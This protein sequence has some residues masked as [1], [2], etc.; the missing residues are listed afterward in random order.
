MRFKWLLPFS[1]PIVHDFQ[2]KAVPVE[3]QTASPPESTRP[4]R[5]VPQSTI[6][7]NPV[8]EP[9]CRYLLCISLAGKTLSFGPSLTA[10]ESLTNRIGEFVTSNIETLGQEVGYDTV[11]DLIISRRSRIGLGNHSVSDSGYYSPSNDSDLIH[12]HLATPD[13]RHVVVASR[14][15]GRT[16]FHLAE[17]SD[18]RAG[19]L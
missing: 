8:K 6:L 3:A 14:A 19:V 9:D 10:V 12:D 13:S 16:L 4:L 15:L 2:S 18:Q 17:V 1:V 11:T 7:I 5:T